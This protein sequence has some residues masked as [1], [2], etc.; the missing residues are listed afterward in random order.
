MN[1]LGYN[2]IADD[3]VTEKCNSG[4]V[5]LEMRLVHKI[6]NSKGIF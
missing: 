1:P 5:S 4:H 3:K 6:T 2:I